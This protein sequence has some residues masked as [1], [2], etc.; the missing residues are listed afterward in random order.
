MRKL[1]TRDQVGLGW[2]DP[3]AASIFTHLD[4]IDVVEVI[5][6]EYFGASGRMLRSMRALAREV[7]LVLH[8]VALGLASVTPV[9]RKRVDRLA[10]VVNALEPTQWSEHLAFVRGGS[11]EIGHLAAPPRNFATVE[12]AANNIARVRAVVGAAPALENVATLVDPPD[13]PLA[14]PDWVAAILAA[15]A[16]PALLDLHNLYANAVNFGHDPGEYLLKFPL[17]RVR[18]VH[19]SGG[20]WI[21]L[22]SSEYGLTA[23]RL[24]DD[25]VHDVP[26]AVFAMLTTLGRCCAQPLTVI[27]ERDGHYPEFARLL[28]QV[29]HARE[30]L[31]EGRR[32]RSSLLRV[33]MYELATI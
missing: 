3:L 6:D 13:S 24:L 15:S 29:A 26:E 2:R 8:G 12:G 11:Y 21:R 17:D 5:A 4:A 9:A 27:L 14:E 18:M 7:S 32:R 1:S 16:S 10:K 28:E 20:H 33:E 19:I 31:A 25:H 22:D 30:A 23:R